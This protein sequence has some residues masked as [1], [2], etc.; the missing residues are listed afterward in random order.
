MQKNV[1]PGLARPDCRAEN[2]SLGPARG[3]CLLSG[4]RAVGPGLSKITS[5]PCL[6]L[7]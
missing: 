6:D 4:H 2:L 5:F 3:G 7:A 1:G